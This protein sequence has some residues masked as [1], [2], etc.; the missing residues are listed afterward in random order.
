MTAGAPA[1]KTFQEAVLRLAWQSRWR[2]AIVCGIILC[3]V[4]LYLIPHIL[5]NISHPPTPGANGLLSTPSPSARPS[6]ESAGDDIQVWVN[7]DSGVYHCPKTRWFGNTKKGKYMTQGEAVAEGNRPAYG[8]R[9]Q[10]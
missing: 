9:C 5:K 8:K 7:T 3:V 4:L 1:P 10:E 2:V 6:S